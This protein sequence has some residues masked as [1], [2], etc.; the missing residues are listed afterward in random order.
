M[1][2]KVSKALFCSFGVKSVVVE[3]KKWKRGV[4]LFCCDFSAIATWVRW[5]YFQDLRG[6]S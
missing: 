4:L 3:G 1:M 2:L 5:S 6:E